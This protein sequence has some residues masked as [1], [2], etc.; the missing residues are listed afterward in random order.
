VYI[1]S[2]P[3]KNYKY[4]L[5]TED[6]TDFHNMIIADLFNCM[7]VNGYFYIVINELINNKAGALGYQWDLR[8]L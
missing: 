8:L 2:E 7:R 5:L 6:D 1:F 4:T 3:G